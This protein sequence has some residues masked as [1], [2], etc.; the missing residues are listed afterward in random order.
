MTSL[1][2][3]F[4]IEMPEV[5]AVKFSRA[6]ADI[7]KSPSPSSKKTSAKGPGGKVVGPFFCPAASYDGHYKPNA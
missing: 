1:A 3:T 4:G 5:E 7:A 2:E 6:G